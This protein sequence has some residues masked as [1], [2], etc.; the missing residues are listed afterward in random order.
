MTRWCQDMENEK[1]SSK[2]ERKKNKSKQGRK[3]IQWLRFSKDEIKKEG[4]Q[5]EI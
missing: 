4:K 1:I 2:N 3:K 5:Q